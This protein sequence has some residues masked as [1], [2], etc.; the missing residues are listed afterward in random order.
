YLLQRR[1]PRLREVVFATE[2]Q[3][4]AAQFA[5]RIATALERTT[6]AVQGPPGAGKTFVG[7]QMIR[8][9]VRAGRR[10]GVTAASHKVIQNL[11]DAV[12]EQ[13][14]AA[15]EHIL[16]ARKPGDDEE[17]RQGVK[18]FKE[19]ATAIAAIRARET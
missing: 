2:P 1:P 7:A 3:E 19:N 10:V 16:L 14:E 13:A 12:R 11:F 9:A 15:G 5:V 6:L 18:A 8:A 17:V 4:S